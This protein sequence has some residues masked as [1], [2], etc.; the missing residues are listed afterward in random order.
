MGVKFQSPVS[1]L[2]TK[3]T[4]YLG[5]HPSTAQSCFPRSLTGF[6]EITQKVTCIQILASGSASREPDIRHYNFLL[7]CFDSSSSFFQPFKM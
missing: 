7:S 3:V 6:T 4:L 2:Q 1:V 5:P